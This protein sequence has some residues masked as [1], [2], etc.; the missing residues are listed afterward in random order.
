MHIRRFTNLVV[1]SMALLIVVS[2][3]YVPVPVSAQSSGQSS[4]LNPIVVM[5]DSSHNPRFKA[6]DASSGFKLMLDMVNESTRYVV[7]V[8]THPL[9]KTILNGVDVL[10]I[11]E[12]DSYIPYITSETDAIS[13]MLANGSSLFLLGDPMIDHNSTYWN[14]PALSSMGENQGVNALL[15]QL[16]IT[17]PRFSLN[18]T[19]GYVFSDTMF[20]YDHAINATYP[21]VIQ[22]DSSTWDT[23]NPI[24]KD[25]NSL[26]TMTAT[27]KPLKSPSEIAH[28][29]DTTFAQFRRG[30]NDFGN[31]SYP[32]I[33]LAEFAEHPLSYSAIN[34]TFPSWMSAF[35][36]GKS[37]VVMVGSALM[38]SGNHLDIPSSTDA[39]FYQADNSRLF[40]NILMWL[41]YGFVESPDAIYPMAII[42]SVILLVGIAV[43]LYKKLR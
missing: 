6:D 42:S 1:L 18:S 31:L 29:Y 20:D 16:N 37:R 41:T 39:W 40:M 8:N 14:T 35:G 25:I 13:S 24:F 5:Y 4:V 11:A 22:L 3:L 36:Y 38:F 15:D 7:R 17:G 32:N 34:G 30:P 33:T 9:N 2:S 10:I 27:F 12:P 19:E 23:T 21:S 26:V 43:Y 28:S